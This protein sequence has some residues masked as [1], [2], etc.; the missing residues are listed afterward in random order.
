[1]SEEQ[2]RIKYRTEYVKRKRFSARQ[3]QIA[4][5]ILTVVIIAV[6]LGVILTGQ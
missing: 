5:I 4:A 2:K 6:L 1:M 3:L